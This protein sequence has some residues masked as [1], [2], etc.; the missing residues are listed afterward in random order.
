MGQ[1]KYSCT[2]FNHHTVG[3][4]RS[5]PTQGVEL[6][7][8]EKDTGHKWGSSRPPA[9]RQGKQLLL[10]HCIRGWMDSGTYLVSNYNFLIAQPVA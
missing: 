4:R 9:L 1:C 3:E 6:M 2:H 8:E 10:P 5:S 7:E